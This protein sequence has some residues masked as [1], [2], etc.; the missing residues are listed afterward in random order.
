MKDRTLGIP[1]KEC[2]FKQA[3][4]HLTL[5]LGSKPAKINLP[6]NKPL[7][8]LSLFDDYQ[9]LYAQHIETFR[10]YFSILHQNGNRFLQPTY[11]QLMEDYPPRGMRFVYL[12]FQNKGKTIGFAVGQVLN[13]NLKETLLSENSQDASFWNS[14]RNN[15]ANHFNFQLLVCGT[16]TVTGQHGFFFR[17]EVPKTLIPQLLTLGFNTYIQ[18]VDSRVD[19]IM[20]KDLGKDNHDWHKYWKEGNFSQVTFQPNMIFEIDPSWS[21]YGDYLNAMTSKYRVRAKRAQKKAKAIQTRILSLEDIALYEDRIQGLYLDIAQK[22]DFNMITLHPGYLKALKERLGDHFT[23]SGY[24]L[25]ETLI[26]FCTTIENGEDLEA[27]FLGVDQEANFE[28][29]LYLN[30]LYDMVKQ[31]IEK[32]T[33]KRIIFGRTAPEIKSSVGA[34][35]EQVYCYFRHRN[36][37]INKMVPS[38]ISCFEPKV[39]WTP[40]HPFGH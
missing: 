9:V 8:Q 25:G 37:L 23:M 39:E 31:G 5:L 2:F 3:S 30:M 18:K 35:A 34:R 36:A 24:F 1:V 29:Q 12:L 16:T 13:F 17:P 22:A 20:I 4:D 21:T 32:G 10:P 14:I 7:Q 27:H 38:L 19:T 15:V 40:R 28:Y 11:L 26:G 6:Q 33:V